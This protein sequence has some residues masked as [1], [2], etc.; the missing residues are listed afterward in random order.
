MSVFKCKMCGGDLNI[1]DGQTIAEC[2]YCGTKQT[3]PALDDEK[4]IQL[5]SRANRLR[6]N[7]E[8]DKA[9]GIYE[10][11]VSDFPEE[12][13]AYWGMLLCK[14]GIE[15]VDDPATAK[16]VPTCHRSSFDSI[17][18][19]ESF[20][21]VMEYSD[22]LA[23]SVYREEA[24]VIENIRKGIVEVSS[25]EEPYDIFICYKET[26][27][28]GSR[29]VDSVIAQDVYD[30]LTGKGYKVFFSRITLED[31]L[32]VEYEPYIFAALNS[33]KIMLAFGT[34]YEYY[35]AVWVKNEWG[36]FLKIIAAD[37]NKYLIPCFKDIDAYDMPKEFAKLQSQDMGKVGAIQDLLRGIEKIIPL[38]KA[39]ME[40]VIVKE[41][42]GSSSVA[43]LLKRVF[44]FLEDGKWSDADEYSEKVLDQDPE[45]AEAY[46]GKLMAEL[47]VRTKDE[48][49]N[50]EE[51]FDSSDN[52]IKASRFDADIAKKLEADNALIRERITD[53][54][55]E[56]QKTAE[57]VI[58]AYVALKNR[59]NKLRDKKENEQFLAETEEQISRLRELIAE[60]PH[61][62][63]KAD[64]LNS[65]LEMT[66][67]KIQELGSKLS[68]LG[69]FGG[70]EKK[71]LKELIEE[72]TRKE[73]KLK[74]EV[75]A[76][77]QQLFG[78]SNVSEIEQEITELEKKAEELKEKIYLNEAELCDF[79]F[80]TVEEVKEYLKAHPEVNK[81]SSF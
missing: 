53:R 2:E 64:S 6:F 60:F 71:Q 48:L 24:K 61:T 76:A 4:K 35:D 18:D 62:K 10:T 14:Y 81:V 52:C 30:A 70:K 12:P 11:I 21:M 5:F 56:I 78:Y 46:L 25:K 43:P 3:V 27:E 19:D 34:K 41:T 80:E 15:Y 16:K 54:Q 59:E 7:C 42:Q 38:Q 58:E 73:E 50:C 37:H 20:E 36:R 33:A 17:F 75:S 66:C 44:M 22:T 28:N 68:G 63:E 49:K 67:Q 8:F 79:R 51:P 26:D 74:A 13:E 69:L 9:S 55:N 45:C 65:Q 57:E 77:R 40:T 72:E 32:G 39:E 47:K 1:S 23:K 31:K 29:T